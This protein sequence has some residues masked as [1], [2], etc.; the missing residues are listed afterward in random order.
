MATRVFVDANVLCSQTLRDWLF[1]LKLEST[2]AGT[3]AVRTTWTT[4]P[5]PRG[6][7]IA[8][9]GGPGDDHA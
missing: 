7:V 8:Q 9:D 3:S 1:L 4:T 2:N 5:A 6:G